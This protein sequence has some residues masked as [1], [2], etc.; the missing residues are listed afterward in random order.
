MMMVQH[1]IIQGGKL[2]RDLIM[3]MDMGNGQTME[4]NGQNSILFAPGES[5]EI[6]WAFNQKLT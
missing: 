6:I 5:G 4:H 1:G 3:K 2:N